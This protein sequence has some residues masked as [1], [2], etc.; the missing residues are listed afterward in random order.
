VGLACHNCG[1][2]RLHSS[3]QLDKFMDPRAEQ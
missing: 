3:H 1:Y 2:I